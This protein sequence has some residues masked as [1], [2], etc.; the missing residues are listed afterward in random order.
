MTVK[1]G[2]RAKVSAGRRG[3]TPMDRTIGIRLRARRLEQHMSQ[4]V[5]AQQLGVSFQQ[6]QKYE[7]GVNRV[8]SARLIEIAHI[9][10]SDT[11]YFLADPNGNGNKQQNTTASRFGEFLATID[12]VKIV[13]AMMR[14]SLSH[15]RIVIDLAQSLV[16]AYGE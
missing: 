9:L 4:E 10:Q 8:G 1:L 16:K 2:T 14:L 6:V 3:V 15:Q 13:E 11:N 12:G 7:K 5:L